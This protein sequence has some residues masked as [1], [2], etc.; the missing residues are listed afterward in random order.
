MNLLNRFFLFFVVG[1]LVVL[2][3]LWI[4]GGKEEKY[5]AVIEIDASVSQVFPY[6]I[7]PN[8]LT[9]WVTGLTQVD[10]PLPPPDNPSLAPA[11]IRTVTNGKGS[12]TVFQDTVIRY[13]Q[14]EMLSIRSSAGGLTYTLVYQLEPTEP[15]KARLTH[16]VLV[17]FSGLERFTAP[18]LGNNLQE[19]VV[20]DV[21]R[22][23]ELVEQNEKFEPTTANPVFRDPQQ[24]ANKETG[25]QQ[26]SSAE[27]EEPEYRV[28]GFG[29]NSNHPSVNSLLTI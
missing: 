23:K 26:N 3:G 16:T 15:G 22:L 10:K 11:L 9:Q 18:I 19:Q 8:K 1:L 7:E 25:E 5:T 20:A 6:L 17:S 29:F 12:A 2:A 24:D 28:P 14:D 21:R 27:Q 13:T 4:A